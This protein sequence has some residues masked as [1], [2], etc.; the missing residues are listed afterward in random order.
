MRRTYE[1]PP[2][3]PDSSPNTTKA[4]RDNEDLLFLI[5]DERSKLC[6]LERL[7]LILWLEGCGRDGF[8]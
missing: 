2:T 7:G 4:A 6:F 3:A 1:S 8:W 5:F